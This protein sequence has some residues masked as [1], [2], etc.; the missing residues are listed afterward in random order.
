ML[1]KW[2]GRDLSQHRRVKESIDDAFS[3]PA[4]QVEMHPLLSALDT[5]EAVICFQYEQRMDGGKRY[6]WV[7][8]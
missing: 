5:I 4:R 3:Q 8:D 2:R 1:N 6:P 7:C